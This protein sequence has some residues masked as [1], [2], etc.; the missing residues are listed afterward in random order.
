MSNLK[1]LGNIYIYIHIYI[2]IYIIYIYIT[3]NS[4]PNYY[5]VNYVI[6][7]SFKKCL[8]NLVLF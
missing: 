6:Q 5:L 3:K 2:Y 8:K 4:K 1:S 7:V